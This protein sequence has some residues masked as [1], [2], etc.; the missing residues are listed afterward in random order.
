MFLA[1]DV[2]DKGYLSPKEWEVLF[3]MWNFP[4]IETCA[5]E[6]FKGAD[7]NKDGQISLEEFQ[8]YNVSLYKC[9]SVC[10]CV[11]EVGCS[12]G[13]TRRRLVTRDLRTSIYRTRTPRRMFE[14]AWAG[15]ATSGCNE[16]AAVEVDAIWEQQSKREQLGSRSWSRHNRGAAADSDTILN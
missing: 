10:V 4:D 9:V 7:K 5:V 3:Y 6:P 15:T 2:D 13:G 11:T 14:H 8:E 16:G 1:L 12:W